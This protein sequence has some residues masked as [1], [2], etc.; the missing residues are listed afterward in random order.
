MPESRPTKFSI[1]LS[2]INSERAFPEILAIISPFFTLSP[3][4]LTAS[5]TAFAS[6][7]FNVIAAISTPAITPSSRERITHLAFTSDGTQEMV[8]MS[9]LLPKSSR[10]AALMIGSTIWY[11]RLLL[12]RFLYYLHLQQANKNVVHLYLIV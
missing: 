5:K 11:G 3:L 7:N 10:K 4:C 12:I 8:V 6:T 9:P 1:T 2:A